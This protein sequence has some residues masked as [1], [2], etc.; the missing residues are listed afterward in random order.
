MKTVI[1][2]SDSHCRNR[3]ALFALAPLFAENDFIVH[4]GDGASDMREI[5]SRYPQKTYICRGNCDLAYGE[6][7]FVFEAEGVSVLCCHG[8]RW[9]VKSGLSR[10]AAH[11][12]E[13]GCTVAL[14]GHTH[15]AD[16]AEED[17]VLCVNPGALGD[18]TEPSYCYLVL[19][20]GKATATIVNLSI[21]S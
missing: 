18:Y 11:A 17:G 5:S 2:L 4:L 21:P 15:R 14:Y 12:K 16:I 3:Q 8:H 13:L 6:E 20:N 19:H 10:L 9:G 7:E 1:V